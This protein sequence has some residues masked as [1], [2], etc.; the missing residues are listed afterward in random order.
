MPLVSFVTIDD[1]DV[2]R[3]VMSV[4]FGNGPREYLSDQRNNI[5]MLL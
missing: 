3:Y 1:V 4:A 5:K 2:S